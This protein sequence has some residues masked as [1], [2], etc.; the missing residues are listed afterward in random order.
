MMI[1]PGSFIAEN[2][3]G[4]TREEAVKEVKR[5]WREIRRLRKML[6]EESQAEEMMYPTGLG[7]VREL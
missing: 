5:L 2:I 4:K 3:E 1:G 6:E 7:Q